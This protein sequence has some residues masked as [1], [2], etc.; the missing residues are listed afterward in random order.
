MAGHPKHTEDQ[1]SPRQGEY[2]E[3]TQ[4][5][6]FAT[7]SSAAE[8]EH[9]C[10]ESCDKGGPKK[11]TPMLVCNGN[12]NS[13]P[14]AQALDLQEQ[15]QHSQLLE[16]FLWTAAYGQNDCNPEWQPEAQFRNTDRF[17][18]STPSPDALKRSVLGQSSMCDVYNVAE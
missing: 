12:L 15:E 9:S 11:S 5:R 2:V 3:V 1:Q 8:F 14:P 17:R 18:A 7:A 6:G 13:L 4:A 16:H 10:H